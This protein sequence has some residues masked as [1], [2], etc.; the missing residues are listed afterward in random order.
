VLGAFDDV[1]SLE[2]GG[3][4]QPQAAFLHDAPGCGVD[5]HGVREHPPDAKVGESHIAQARD[6]LALII[7]A[8]GWLGRA[9]AEPLNGS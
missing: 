5:R 4:H 9:A 3:V 2:R 7:H 6:P 1:G 8:D